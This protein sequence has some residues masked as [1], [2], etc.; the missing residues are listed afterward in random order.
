M[1]K[2]FL[3]FLVVCALGISHG[4]LNNTVLF[5]REIVRILDSHCVMCHAD[6]GPAFPLET[7]E[8]TWLQ[9]HPIYLDVISRHMPPWPAIPGYGIFANDNALT[10]RENQFIVSW[11]E[12]LGPRNAGAVFS[13]TAAAGAEQPAEVRAHTDFG[14]WQFGE[15]QLTR[16]LFANTIEPLQANQVKRTAVDLGLT[17]PRWLRTLEYMPGDYRVARAAVFTIQETGQWVGSWTPWYGYLSLPKGTAIRLPAGAHIMAEIHY[18]GGKERITDQGKLGLTFAPEPAPNAVSDIVLDAKAVAA[19]GG[20]AGRLRGTL[21]LTAETHIVALRTESAANLKSI[22]VS[23]RKPDGGAEVLLYAKDFQPDWPTPY[24]YK[25]PVVLP[26]GAEL[27]VTAYLANPGGGQAAAF[28]L[29]ASAFHKA[30]AQAP[31]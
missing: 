7:Y 25:D 12:G 2:S 1:K 24:I 9:M 11:V 5:D 16:Q 20:P 30:G 26:G 21:K 13:N 27:T 6:K 22:E 17:A 14:H 23:A 18:K 28:R 3:L 29:T 31:R 15:P 4:T 10:L 19:G 8:Q